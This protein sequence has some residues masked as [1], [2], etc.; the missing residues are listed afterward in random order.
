MKR[1]STKKVKAVPTCPAGNEALEGHFKPV[2][3]K[4][5]RRVR[6]SVAM[7][8]LTI[9]MGAPNLLLT[10]QSDRTPAAEPVGNEPTVS[11]VTDATVANLDVSISSVKPE[12]VNSLPTGASYSAV[13]PPTFQIQL[14]VAEVSTPA[15]PVVEHT[16]QEE[17]TPKQ[18][19]E[20]YQVDA[21]ARPIRSF[22]IAPYNSLA[23]HRQA[24]KVLKTPPLNGIVQKLKAGR[25]VETP[26]KFYGAKRSEITPPAVIAAD[27]QMKVDASPKVTAEVNASLKAKQRALINR[28]KQKSN[29]LQN[30]LAKLRSEESTNSSRLAPPVREATVRQQQ[31]PVEQG[32]TGSSSR[33]V[34]HLEKSQQT[35]ESAVVVP[36][37]RSAEAPTTNPARLAPPVAG[38]N[39]R[40]QQSPVERGFTGSSSWRAAPLSPEVV[41]INENT[42]EELEKAQQT[43]DSAVVV[44][45]AATLAPLSPEVTTSNESKGV[46]GEVHSS[47]RAVL[48]EQKSQET[49][50]SA[51]VV[52]NMPKS[53]V[54]EPTVVGTSVSSDYQVKPGDTLSAIAHNYGVSLSEV[55]NANQLSD[56]DRLEINQQ[57]TI[58][59]FQ[60][61]NPGATVVVQQPPVEG[62]FNRSSSWHA[63]SL[64][65]QVATSNESEQVEVEQVHPPQTGSSSPA[66]LDAQKL[67]QTPVAA[68][69]VPNI[70]SAVVN[71]PTVVVVTSV[72]PDYQVKA[73]DTLSA[74][75]RNYGISLSELV[76]VNQ[77]SD[78]DLLQIN[79]RIT[80]PPFQ[81]SSAVGQ[82]IAVIKRSNHPE[83]TASSVSVSVPTLAM[84]EELQPNA[85]L[86]TYKRAGGSQQGSLEVPS[87]PPAGTP[88]LDAAFSG[89]GGSISDET[90]QLSPP[91][92]DE[93]TAAKP[94]PQSNPYAQNLRNDIQRLRQKYYAQQ[95]VS[96]VVPV[97]SET[98]PLP[99]PGT[100]TIPS[101]AINPQFR[102]NNPANQPIN[103]EF[104]AAPKRSTQPSSTLPAIPRGRVAT[105]PMNLYPSDS[106]ES[107]RGRQQVSPELPPLAPVDNYLPQPDS[108][109]APFKGYIWP[110]K[111]VLTSRYGWRWGRM[112]K[113]I[114][115]AAPI[116]TPV[117]AAAPGFVIRAGWNYG[118]YGN[119]V[120]VQHADGSV[121]RYAHNKRLLVQ[122]GQPVKQGQQISEMGS[123]GYSTGPHLHFEVHPVGKGAVNPIAYLPR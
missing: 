79:Q 84:T 91:T 103:P 32:F 39:V 40:K 49:P 68:V 80:I 61:S 77:L 34:F 28:L 62:E 107:V 63:A 56:P 73:G 5:K 105:A 75:A 85:D 110:T 104:R 74:I 112:H 47:S 14:K 6:T 89:V 76:K 111:G 119:L 92:F 93:T 88:S 54:N 51:V 82:A 17:Q 55:V 96:Q 42:V 121:T 100:A 53:A 86:I 43:P 94:E 95:T 4:V 9:S 10:R 13:V 108:T 83:T 70:R 16:V 15:P 45:D 59:P 12:A 102:P 25:T 67:E 38:A 37:M 123:T 109:S 52:P 118:G 90:D 101:T 21:P 115:I 26:S 65:P 1:A 64:S 99:A 3:S 48:D 24:G 122:R 33:A 117:L 71:E 31:S 7:I 81:Y 78:P 18:I 116:G 66:V 30:S 106:L 98:E 50:S 113:G 69:L 23:P 11:T 120:D 8:G 46:E 114:D 58:P 36:D 97:V 35:P 57:I 22:V 27:Q 19:S 2:Q 87:E 41:K 29:R 72:S 60:Y 20:K 44:P